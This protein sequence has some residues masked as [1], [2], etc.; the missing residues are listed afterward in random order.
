MASL[1]WGWIPKPG[2]PTR[3]SGKTGGMTWKLHQDKLLKGKKILTNYDTVFSDD[4]I[5]ADVIK[6]MPEEL[7]D[8]SLGASEV[9]LFLEKRRTQRTDQIMITYAISQF[10]KRRVDFHW[11]S[12]DI[13]KV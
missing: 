1:I 13:G 5:T 3:G 8:C 7:R 12:Q 9:H 4:I 6:T 2:G 11:D 10:R